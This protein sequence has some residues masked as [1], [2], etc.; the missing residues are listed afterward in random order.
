LPVLVLDEDEANAAAL[1]TTLA[2][3]G[4]APT[5]AATREEARRWLQQ[6]P[7]GVPFA[8]FICAVAAEGAERFAPARALLQGVAWSGPLVVVLPTGAAPISSSERS[9]LPVA[10]MLR[11][12]FVRSE[13]L[14]A[15]Q[16]ALHHAR[17]SAAEW[18]PAR[19]DAP[20]PAEVQQPL[21]IL[22]AEDNAVNRKFACR[23]LEKLGHR[24]TA[25]E[26][27][28]EVLEQLDR[29]PVDLVLMDML[30]PVLDGYAATARIRAREQ[31]Q[32]GRL[33]II[34]VTANAMPGDRERCMATGMDG[35]VA[36][37]L[38]R[39]L[40]KSEIARVWQERR[41]G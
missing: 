33:P 1:H 14:E 6:P 12:P 21:H 8:V 4:M 13:L 25:V 29:E 15:V 18:T 22:I 24:V 26:N 23:L 37:P 34:A 10:A 32:G 35:Y 41:E 3:W 17:P 36:K 27:G 19:E 20:A 11:Q 9:A 30:M 39:E 7:D 2:H 16:A 38:K 28:Q 5:L 40:L 31:Q